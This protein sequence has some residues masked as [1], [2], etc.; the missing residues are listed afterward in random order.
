MNDSEKLATAIIVLCNSHFTPELTLF[1]DGVVHLE[2]PLP[3]C[4][5]I[6]K[7]TDIST[8]IIADKTILMALEECNA[9]LSHEAYSI[10]SDGIFS[11]V[12]SSESVARSNIFDF[13]TFT[14][15][16]KFLELFML[17]GMGFTLEEER[18]ACTRNADTT[19]TGYV[20]SCS[21]C[22]CASYR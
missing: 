10:A 7:A 1:V 8:D 18:R 2:Y 6:L 22:I 11:F 20:L 19:S 5:L 15:D 12:A 9:L 21:T 3:V 16:V 13:V 17:M 14:Y 4:K